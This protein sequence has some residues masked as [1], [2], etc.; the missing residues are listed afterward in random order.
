MKTKNQNT[1]VATQAKNP[2]KLTTKWTAPKTVVEERIIEGVPT[3][4]TV[5]LNKEQRAI[6]RAERNLQL[7]KEKANEKEQKLL[8][9]QQLKQQ[10]Q[11]QKA[12]ILAEKQ[13]LKDIDKKIDELRNN[14]IKRTGNDLLESIKQKTK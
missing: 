13:K 9:R 8:Q 4:V 6:L 11:A 10:K 3:K 12:V 5:I 2:R 7:A 1:K 14:T